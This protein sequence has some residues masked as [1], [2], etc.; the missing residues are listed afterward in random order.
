M[1]AHYYQLL[2]ITAQASAEEIKRAY[3]ARALQLHP[4]RNPAPDA[5]EKFIALTEA[6][7]YVIAEKNGDFRKYVSP[8]QAAE[9]AAQQ[10][11]E[12]AL[13]K[14]REYARMR[15]EEFEKTEA[16]QAISAL[17]I[18]LDHLIFLF[19]CC[20]L[21]VIPVVLSY[22]YE[23]TGF[24]LS[25]LFLL[26]VARPAFGFIRHY[27]NP[28]QLA[29]AIMQLSGTYFFRIVIVS[30]TNLY[31]FLSIGLQ[32]MLPVSVTLALLVIP[33]IV[34]YF[35]IVRKQAAISRS[36]ISFCLVPFAVNALLLLNYRGSRNPVVEEY[37]FSNLDENNRTSTLIHLESQA[38]DNY[39][40]I[41]VFSNYRQMQYSTHI[42]YQ[43][44]DGLL[45]I[46]VMKE[47]RFI[48]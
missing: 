13:R 34:C 44:E 46:R 11:R 28:K 17:N 38:Y 16:F 26:I 36:F 48:N 2:G 33:G 25:A 15:Y 27:F 9:Q 8:V 21:M 7:E 1:S 23:V 24:I 43:F 5:Q 10:R 14:A 32:T 37:A 3:R 35:S 47:Y 12:E 19:A 42:V 6:Y 22:F 41:R 45:G 20:L 18:I 29:Q 30:L 39:A 40:G 4:D 31:L